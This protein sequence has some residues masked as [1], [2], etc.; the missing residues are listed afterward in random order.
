MNRKIFASFSTHQF[1]TLTTIFSHPEIVGSHKN[2]R[3]Q[4]MCVYKE[5]KTSMYL[6]NFSRDFSSSHAIEMYGWPFVSVPS[7]IKSTTVLSNNT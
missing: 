7:L 1:S 2:T 4:G 3:Y 6:H 5:S